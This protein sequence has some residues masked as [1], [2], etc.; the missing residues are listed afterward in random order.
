MDEVTLAERARRLMSLKAMGN[1][2]ERLID[3]PSGLGLPAELAQHLQEA[4]ATTPEG[5][6]AIAPSNMKRR[7]AA[8]C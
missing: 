6:R 2:L 5:E 1:Y 7:K 4:E 8:G 3:M